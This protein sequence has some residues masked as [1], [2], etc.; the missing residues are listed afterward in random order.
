MRV[1]LGLG[2]IAVAAIGISIAPPAAADPSKDCQQVG[3]TTVC[4]QG[5]VSG[6]A[7]QS[8]APTAPADS[9]SVGSCSTPYGT[10]QRC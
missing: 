1:I 2:A 8:A 10:Y 5:T 6:G 4:G 3:A 9:P 7:D